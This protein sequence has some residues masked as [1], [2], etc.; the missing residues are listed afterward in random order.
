MSTQLNSKERFGWSLD[1]RSPR[2]IQSWLPVWEWL[3]HYYFRVKTSGWHHI[4]SYDNVLLVGSH[5]GGLASPDT[6]MMM[7]D[8]FH[9]FGLER[10]VYGLMH[11]NA[12]KGFP[13]LAQLAAQ[14]GAV[15]AHPKMAIAALRR[16][17][18]VL[19]YPGG[20]PDV[21]RPHSLR[22]TICLNDNQAFIKL[23]LR[24]KV[25]IVPLVSYGAHDTLIVL[26]DIYPVLQ[27]LHEWGMPWMM[28]L[29]PEVFPIYLG[30]PW[31]LAIGPLPNIPLPV[32]IHTRVCPPVTFKRY[33]REA[34]RD[35]E[36]VTACYHKVVSQMQRELDAL[37]DSVE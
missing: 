12:W 36:Y 4:P 5:N 28:G 3:Y 26:T 31:G 23:A 25:P 18:S 11:P 35:Q 6:T 8:W 22:T 15:I 13:E 30:L 32:T 10:P 7:V 27:Q 19:V 20:A 21:F 1:H 9:R 29:D 33:G 2:V 34:A 37:V 16:G 17:A 24:E 14:V